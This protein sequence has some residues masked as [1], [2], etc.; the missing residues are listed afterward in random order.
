M[1]PIS[2]YHL[3]KIQ[4]HV[5]MWPFHW[6]RTCI[7]T[8]DIYEWFPTLSGLPNINENLKKVAVLSNVVWVSYCM[9]KSITIVICD[10]HKPNV[11]NCIVICAYHEPKIDNIVICDLPYAK[12]LMWPIMSQTVVTFVICDLLSA[13]GH[14]YYH[15]WPIISQMSSLLSSVTYY[16]SQVINIV[17]CDLS[18]ANVH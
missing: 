10:Y 3:T 11:I 13:K 17:L 18:W 16:E 5:P 14:L 12:G 15:L 8:Y 7:I 9:P 1:S 4:Q 6:K 2:S